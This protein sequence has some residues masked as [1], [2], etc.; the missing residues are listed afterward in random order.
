M[1]MMRVA[2]KQQQMQFVWMWSGQ[3]PSLSN[4]LWLPRLEPSWFC[5]AAG[6]LL[7]LRH[8]PSPVPP[9]LASDRSWWWACTR[10]PP[11]S[12]GVSWCVWPADRSGVVHSPQ[13]SSSLCRRSEAVAAPRFHS[14]PR[15]AAPA[16][17][18]CL[19]L[20]FSLL[21]FSPP[22]FPLHAHSPP[23][24]SSF[25]LPLPVQS[26][27]V[28]RRGP[29]WSLCLEGFPPSLSGPSEKSGGRGRTL[30]GFQYNT[31]KWPRWD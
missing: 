22:P 2:V 31:F 20:S 24:L 30:W 13:G 19:L 28:R 4:D 1:M 21:P 29:E 23:H 6:P 12:W 9:C 10:S 16:L 17:P 7:L 18:P 5:S 26:L 11:S 8:P 15:W 14:A 3:H 25:S 27:Q